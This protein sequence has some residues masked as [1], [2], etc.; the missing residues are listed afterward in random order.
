MSDLIS[1]LIGALIG[2][3]VSTFSDI[4]K[5]NDSLDSKS[6]WRKELFNVASKEDIGFDEVYRV[7][8]A[9][10]LE[11]NDKDNKNTTLIPYSFSWMNDIMIDYLENLMEQNRN[12]CNKID[13]TNQEIIRIFCRFLL[14]QHWEYRGRL[15]PRTEKKKDEINK[16]PRMYAK[17]T[18]EKVIELV[19]NKHKSTQINVTKAINECDVVKSLVD[20]VEEKLPIIKKSKLKFW[21]NLGFQSCL[22]ILLFV[23]CC[24]FLNS[25]KWFVNVELEKICGLLANKNLVRI[26][27]ASGILTGIFYVWNQS[28]DKYILKNQENQ[29]TNKVNKVNKVNETTTTTTTTIT[30]T[31]VKHNNQ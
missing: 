26:W 13:P 18:I 10:R 29:E 11:K 5:L 8:A 28:I 20:S 14:K 3:A 4:N 21:I 23:S 16:I 2:G 31:Q 27:F 22:Y 19:K 12:G 9:L 17:E 1:G 24:I 15:L 30:T 7:R 25:K 6:G